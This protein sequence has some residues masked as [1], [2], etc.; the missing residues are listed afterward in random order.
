MCPDNR[1]SRDAVLATT[2]GVRPLAVAR[3]KAV[4]KAGRILEKLAP[5]KVSPQR[6]SRYATARAS[7]RTVLQQAQIAPR[8]SQDWR[9]A[10]RVCADAI[11]LVG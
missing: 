2:L 4:V 3:I 1:R 10:G 5:P 8:T 7:Y 11:T 9:A 6:A